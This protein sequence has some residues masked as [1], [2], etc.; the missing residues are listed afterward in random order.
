ME[1]EKMFARLL[2]LGKEWKMLGV[3][4]EEVRGY[5]AECY[6]INMLCFVA[7]KLP[8]PCMYK[9]LWTPCEIPFCP[10]FLLE[11][12]LSHTAK[13][14]VIHPAIRCGM[15]SSRNAVAG[16]VIFAAQP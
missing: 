11:L 8:I 12:F 9:T 6:L 10:G 14:Q 7:G 4:F 15:T 5:R 3:S 2:D 13:P 16:A 1:I